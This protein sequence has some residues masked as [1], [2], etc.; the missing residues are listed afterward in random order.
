MSTR[1]PVLP[2]LAPTPPS[3]APARRDM[4]IPTT[5]AP[6]SSDDLGW[7]DVSF[8]GS[9]QIGTPHIDTIAEEGVA[10]YNY[11]IQPVCSP[12]RATVSSAAEL[13]A[14]KRV[15]FPEQSSA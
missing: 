6:C 1:L 10:L 15:S 5:S 2:S 11:H 13:K 7:N 8:H 3:H 9:T 14:S 12:T 4:L